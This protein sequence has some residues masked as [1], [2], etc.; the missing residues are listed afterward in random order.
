MKRIEDERIQFF[1]RHHKLIRQWA[2]IEPEA[3]KVIN[4]FLQTLGD[5]AKDQQNSAPDSWK[6]C[7]DFN[8]SWPRIL[9][10]LPEWG[11]SEG[12]LPR[13]SIGLEWY[14]PSVDLLSPTGSPYVG[15]RIDP[16][17]QGS[18]ILHDRLQQSCQHCAQGYGFGSERWWPAFKSIPPSDEEFWKDLDA[19]RA[20]LD[21]EFEQAWELFA[22]IVSQTL[23]ASNP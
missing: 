1:L 12:T 3:R 7:W 22:P 17:L 15:V 16:N 8:S 6:I 18:R 20:Q 5:F 13:V 21:K 2:A 11:E 10:F 23:R 14:K 9:R 19:Y 4:E